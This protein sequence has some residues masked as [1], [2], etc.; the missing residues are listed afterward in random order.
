VALFIAVGLLLF[1]ANMQR[2][3]SHDEHMYVAG[4]DLLARGLGLPYRD[5]PYLQMP[6]LVFIYAGLFNVSSY[7]LLSARLFSTLSALGTLLLVFS[8]ACGWLRTSSY[9]ARF[10]IAAGSVLLIINSPIFA[11]TSGQ[12]WNHDAALLFCMGAFALYSH[13]ARRI[14]PKSKFQSPKLRW[15]L[16]V[17]LL[18][19]LAVG[20]R[21]LFLFVVPLFALALIM[22]P[23]DPPV[24]ERLRLLALYLGGVLLGL[25]PS[26]CLFLLAP[27]RFLYGNFVYHQANGDFWERIGYTRAMDP[28]GKLAY[29][30]EVITA[31][32]TL[33]LVTALLALAITAV[34]TRTYRVTGGRREF[35]LVPMLVLAL[36]AGAFVPDPSW[37]QYFFAPLPFLVLCIACCAALLYE[38]LPWILALSAALTLTSFALRQPFYPLE[39]LLAPDRWATIKVHKVGEEIKRQVGS[40]P[41]LTFAPIY[42]LEGGVSIY[43]DFATGPFTWRSIT[44]LSDAERVASGLLSPIELDSLLASEPPSAIL[45]GFEPDLEGPWIE[46]AQKHAYKEVSLGE[47]AILWVAP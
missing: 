7:L 28:V 14:R 25:L 18:A 39:D 27:G 21:L 29:L 20:T 42:P 10:V 45:V 6:N 13:S 15:P 33:L 26:L 8:T 47:G 12:A 46:F 1:S 43:T 17:G 4:G 22:L 5:Y 24:R 31:P 19:G 44:F 3:L 40:G 36:L 11:Y 30:W 41:V 2:G 9:L 34:V 35:Y 16:V 38:R 23:P 37:Y 32:A